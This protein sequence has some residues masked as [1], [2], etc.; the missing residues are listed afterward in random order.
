VKPY[1]K[2]FFTEIKRKV[3]TGQP[4]ST[5]FKTRWLWLVEFR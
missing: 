3:C 2:S 4:H 1:I 5:I